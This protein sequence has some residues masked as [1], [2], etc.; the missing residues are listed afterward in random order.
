MLPDHTGLLEPNEAYVALGDESVHYDI[1]RVGNIIAMRIPSYFSG[2]IRKLKVVSKAV[3]LQRCPEKSR[4]FCGLVTGVVL[5]TQGT[6]SEAEMM[7]GG[8]FD[9]DIGKITVLICL[10]RNI[11]STPN[12]D[13]KTSVVLLERRDCE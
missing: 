13:Y 4:F 5:S 8:D 9:G 7:S 12:P 2:D 1:G 3:L 6:I 10:R 11:T